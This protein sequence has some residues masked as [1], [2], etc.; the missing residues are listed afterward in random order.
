MP[1][2]ARQAMAKRAGGHVDAGRLVHVRVA[3]QHAVEA[4]QRVQVRALEV[5][6]LGQGGIPDGAGVAL[7]E[8]EAVAIGPVGPGWIDASSP[9]STAQSRYRWP[10][11][12]P[13][14]W[15]PPAMDH[16]D[17]VAAD[18]SGHALKI[19]DRGL[20]RRC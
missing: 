8:D 5:A 13:P 20:A 7:G 12:D 4:A 9:G 6:L 16:L 1:S 18:A 10:T 14:G 17:D 11:S 2:P 15:P 3:L 19:G